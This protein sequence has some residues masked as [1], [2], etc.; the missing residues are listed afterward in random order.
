MLV[1]T[2]LEYMNNMLYILF[3][4]D[5]GQYLIAYKEYNYNIG[6]INLYICLWLIMAIISIYFDNN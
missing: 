6:L 2:Y 5:S 1:K 3:L 4:G